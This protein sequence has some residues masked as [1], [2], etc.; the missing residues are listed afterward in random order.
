LILI[1]VCLANIIIREIHKVKE[2]SKE[3]I[4]SIKRRLFI[5]SKVKWGLK[6]WIKEIML[7]S[8]RVQ[9]FLNQGKYFFTDKALRV[10]K[11]RPNIFEKKIWKRS[12]YLGTEL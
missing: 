2:M 7:T 4:E 11:R 6:R 10:I 1:L 3:D 12:H 8:E 9:S 5:C